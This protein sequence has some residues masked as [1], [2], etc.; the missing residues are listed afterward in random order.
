[1][2][3][4]Y[5]VL[6]ASMLLL[7]AACG[8][9]NEFTIEATL[10]PSFNDQMAYLYDGVTQEA[11]DS[12]KIVNGAFTMAG[13]VTEPYIGIIATQQATIPC[14]I[15]SGDIKFNSETNTISG[16]PSQRGL[17]RIHQYA[18]KASFC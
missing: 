2:K 18:R 12:A 7:T 11:L 9:K 5:K 3:L 14:I 1:M 13:E 10:D 8:S 16:T 4:S 17:Q 15:E 6:A